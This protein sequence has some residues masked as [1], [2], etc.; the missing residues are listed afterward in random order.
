MIRGVIHTTSGIPILLIG[1]SEENITRLRKEQ[2]IFQPM[3]GLGLKEEVN[4]AIVYG[5]TEEDMVKSVKEQAEKLG[6]KV[7]VYGASNEPPY[8]M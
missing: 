8:K 2:P 5:K 6:A 4:L 7:W 3:A 1:L